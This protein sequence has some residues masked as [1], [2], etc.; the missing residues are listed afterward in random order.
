MKSFIEAQFS[1]CPLV[2]MFYGRKLN[3]NINHIH[4][5]LLRIAYKYYNKY[6]AIELFK[7]KENIFQYNDEWYF[8]EKI[9][10]ARKTIFPFSKC[11]EKMIF[12][13]KLHWNMI[14]LVLPG[15]S[16]FSN[17]ATDLRPA[18]LLGLQ[19]Y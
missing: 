3:R 14:F 19:L 7:V 2:W 17:K 9:I 15:K 8:E 18:A 12:P 13:K 1:S 11:F 16:L 6:L 10:T 5:R 4:E